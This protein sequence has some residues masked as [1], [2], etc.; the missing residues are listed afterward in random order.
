MYRQ[1]IEIFETDSNYGSIV[2]LDRIETI[3][4]HEDD[5]FKI[6][7]IGNQ[8]ENVDGVGYANLVKQLKE[9]TR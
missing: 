2:F 4:Q 1:Y 7:L 9:I 6:N 8:D 3:I 5:K